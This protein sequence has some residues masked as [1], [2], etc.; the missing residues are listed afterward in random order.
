MYIIVTFRTSYLIQIKITNRNCL[1]RIAIE[2]PNGVWM[3]QLTATLEKTDIEWETLKKLNKTRAKTYINKK[4]A[5]YQRNKIYKAAETKSKVRDYISYRPRNE[6]GRR[7]KYMNKLTRNECADI[8]KSRARMI[9]L[10]NN[11]KTMH[12]NTECRWCNNPDETLQ[13][14]LTTCPTFA[15]G[16]G[17]HTVETC[18]SDELRENRSIA[19]I[20]NIINQKLDEH[21]NQ[22]TLN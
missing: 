20:L 21:N 11:Y 10:K 19:K 7:P 15:M 5:I 1:T 14:I 12:N 8:F 2:D 3:K 22:E 4:L 16:R 17:S 18:F 6:I 13:H 9:K